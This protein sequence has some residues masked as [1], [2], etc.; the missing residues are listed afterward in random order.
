MAGLCLPVAVGGLE[1]QRL[2]EGGDRLRLERLAGGDHAAQ[3]GEG[4][5]GGALGQHPVLGRRLAEHV[6]AERL[7][8]VEPLGWVEATVVDDRGGT[9][10]PGGEKDVARRLRPARRRRAPNQ[11]AVARAEPVLGLGAL[12]LQV[13]IG[14]HDPPRL[15]GG[16]RGEDDQRRVL[17]I[18]RFDRRR[19]L[20][21]Q[22]LVERPSDLRHRHR[23]HAVRQLGEQRLLANAEL[24]VGCSDPQL[25]IVPAQLR[26]AGQRHRPHPPASKQRE[27][28][29]DPVAHQ[30]HHHVATFHAARSKRPREPGGL[31]NQFPEVPVPPIPLSINSN[32]PQPRG[33]GLLHDVFDEVHAGSLA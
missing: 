27:H 15:T 11:L 20:L 13:A 28:P 22:V 8:E 26:V 23:R 25:K 33:R 24:R 3:G 18:H 32:D 17:G 10:Q 16:A 6:D 12:S 4:A 5:Q 30:R 7:G 9:G 29:L 31:G 14:V 21:R 19:C 1:S 2:A